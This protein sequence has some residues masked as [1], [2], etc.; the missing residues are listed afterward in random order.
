MKSSRLFRILFLGA[1]IFIFMNCSK[2]STNPFDADCPKEL[3]TPSD[4]HA[5]QQGTI[6]K[7]SWTQ[8]NKNIDG[9]TISR[10][11]SE[12]TMSE[13]AKIVKSVISWNDSTVKGGTKYGYQLYAYAGTNQSNPLQISITTSIREATIVTESNVS[14]LT[15]NS[16]KLGGN[17][18]SDGGAV[19]TERGICYGITQNPSIAN[20]KVVMGNGTGT[21][22][23]TITGLT[24]NTTYYAKAY[25]T[26]SVGTSYGEIV[27]FSTL[28]EGR[29]NPNWVTVNGG[30]FQMGL[31]KF[32][33]N[34]KP[35]HSVKLNSFLIGKYEVTLSQYIEFLN[36]IKC[37]D[38]GFYNDS[39][40]GYVRY[41]SSTLGIE[42]NGVSYYFKATP[43]SPTND[44]PAL[45]G[46]YGANAFCRW[47]G[48]RLPTEAEW[49]FAA[50]GG[51]KSKGYNFSGSNNYDDV[52]WHSGNSEGKYHPV[53]Q[54]QPNELN[55]YDMS[56][57][58]LEWCNDWFDIDYY[59]KSPFE[60]PQGPENPLP[61]YG[62]YKYKVVR[63]GYWWNNFTFCV[64]TMRS[65]YSTYADWPN[66]SVGTVSSQGFRVAHS[67]P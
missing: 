58:V 56:G 65:G 9:F 19:V 45:I 32:F 54:K 10:N 15:V 31:D 30:T 38:A 17:V 24:E 22:S 5:E 36:A 14:N 64:V 2:E 12:G 66:V 47:V 16:V 20:N 25:A 18:S 39:Q 67:L 4:F 49:E 52:A 13:V 57:N 42:Y 37:Q 8:S 27:S 41:C 3:F 29:P 33:S 21:F 55:I 40:Y 1:F 53:G 23:N 61:D 43:E 60:N 46:W 51:E 35:P 34:P 7:L 6:V 50:R 26:N 11:E 63:G 59:S 28:I 62:N 48:G 44:C